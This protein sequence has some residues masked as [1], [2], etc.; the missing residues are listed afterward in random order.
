M[1]FFALAVHIMGVIL[2]VVVVMY[3]L[4]S[5][6]WGFFTMSAAVLGWATLVS[7]CY[8]SFGGSEETGTGGRAAAFVLNILQVQIFIEAY[9]CI[10]HA[11]DSDYFHTLRLMEAILQSAPQS[12]I[13][14]Y[15]MLLVSSGTTMEFGL[16]MSSSTVMMFRISILLSFLSVA[17]GLAM[18]EQKVQ[19]NASS[20]YIGMVAALRGLEISSR[21]L[22]LALFA[23]LTHP[24][25]FFWALIADYAVML[26]LIARHR[27]V[28][29]A[30]GLFVALPLVFVSL[31]PMVWRR[32]D[33]AVPKDAYYA[34]RVA[35][36]VIMWAFIVLKED[37][38]P[39]RNA[40]GS[41]EVLALLSTLAMY[42][43][44]PLV[45]KMARWHELSREVCDYDEEDGGKKLRGDSEGAPSDSELSGSDSDEPRE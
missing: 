6:A 10:R 24:V 4:S 25:G 33:H 12:L 16:D 43:L 9:R 39:F 42:L 29:L 32:E 11:R 40:R 19:F 38:A 31:E 23:T 1:V 34:V 45:W 14:L 28:Q 3:F 22:T 18:W 20:T 8:I 37:S 5:L 7:S 15:A 27:S 30:Y 41:V 44:M 26:F 2:D 36:F 13:K 35:E 21:S 17:L